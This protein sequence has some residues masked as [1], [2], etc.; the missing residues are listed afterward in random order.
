[1]TSA[2][3]NTTC[4]IHFEGVDERLTSFTECTY[5]KFLE[6]REEWRSVFDNTNE[7]AVKS[8]E[9]IAEGLDFSSSEVQ[10]ASF[11]YT[12]YRRFTD[13]SKLERARKRKAKEIDTCDELSELINPDELGRKVNTRSSSSLVVE[14]DENDGRSKDILPHICLICKKKTLYVSDKVL[15]FFQLSFKCI[16]WQINKSDLCN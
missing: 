3:A 2:T 14:A 10:E 16:A 13:K 7:V 9:F 6:R 1:M 11:H 5:N 8:F 15:S 4:I 12:C